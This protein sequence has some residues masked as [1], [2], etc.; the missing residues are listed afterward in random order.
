MLYDQAAEPPAPGSLL[1]SVFILVANRR[2][3]V[4]YYKSKLLVAA[5]IAPHA[6]GGNKLLQEALD[7]YRYEL[8][9]FLE[10]QKDKAD[11]DS[12]TVLKKW[13]DVGAM[14]IKP[15]W[16]AQDN[17]KIVSKLRRG[18]ERVEEIEQERKLRRHT[19]MR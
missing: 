4:E 5:A 19:R 2:Q 15:L 17:K 11:R 8:F 12:K 14:K 6:E 7:D 16:R 9:P 1:E 3:Q 18:K 10:K 13:A